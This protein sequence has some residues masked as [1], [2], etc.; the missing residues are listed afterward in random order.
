MAALQVALFAA[1]LAVEREEKGLEPQPGVL[2]R[3]LGPDP[4]FITGLVV[5]GVGVLISWIVEAA[6]RHDHSVS[7]SGH[8]VGTTGPDYSTSAYISAYNMVN[9][10]YNQNSNLRAV[11]VK[12]FIPVT[13][14]ES[15]GVAGQDWGSARVPIQTSPTTA[16]TY[17]VWWTTSRGAALTINFESITD[18]IASPGVGM[19]S[20]GW[21]LPMTVYL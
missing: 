14:L 10:I 19:V 20:A 16:T 11:A 8:Y 4:I 15:L 12:A 2:S 21:G 6:A 7:T 5:I 3:Q 17:V 13:G 1:A 18:Y 9:E